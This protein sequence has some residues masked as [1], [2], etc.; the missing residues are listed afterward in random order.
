MNYLI[1]LSLFCLSVNMF[2]QQKEEINFTDKEIEALATQELKLL[3]ENFEISYVIEE[4]LLS[5][6]KHKIKFLSERSLTT[7]Q[8]NSIVK[9]RFT[10][11]LINILNQNNAGK[12]ILLD[13]D[14]LK[15]LNLYELESTKQ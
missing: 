7:E 13:E 10:R 4:Q 14:L 11:R 9:G 8:R 2:A 15:Q 1:I 12:P 3:T 5:F 6:L